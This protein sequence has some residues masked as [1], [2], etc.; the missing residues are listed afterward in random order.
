MPMRTSRTVTPGALAVGTSVAAG[1]APAGACA[2]AARPAP[3]VAPTTPSP[4]KRN[5]RRFIPSPPSRRRE[6]VH[7][8][9]DVED[10]N[11]VVAALDD[12]AGLEHCVER[13][14]RDDTVDSERE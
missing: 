13:L 9:H 2:S 14:H 5:A 3:K 8:L 7:D 12:S 11:G 1:R 6:R 4:V 10:R